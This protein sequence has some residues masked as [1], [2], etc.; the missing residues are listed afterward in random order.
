MKIEALP[1]D[2]GRGIDVI[3]LFAPHDSP[4]DEFAQS[5]AEWKSTDRA[6]LVVLPRRV[7]EGCDADR[8]Q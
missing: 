6:I 2:H 8:P 4:N 3:T 5:V 7:D 1:L